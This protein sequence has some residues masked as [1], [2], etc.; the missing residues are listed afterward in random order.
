[1]FEVFKDA[2]KDFVYWAFVFKDCV[3][4]GLGKNVLDYEVYGVL[5]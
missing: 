4:Y 1:V 2:I 5:V 3:K